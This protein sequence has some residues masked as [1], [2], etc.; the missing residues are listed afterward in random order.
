[1]RWVLY[2]DGAAPLSS[3]QREMRLPQTP[4][5]EAQPQRPPGLLLLGP[6]APWASS[7]P[8]PP[9]GPVA[10]SSCSQPGH[11]RPRRVRS[12]LGRYRPRRRGAGG[13]GARAAAGTM[14][15]IL[16]CPC[17]RRASAIA[18]AAPDWIY[19]PKKRPRRDQAAIAPRAGPARRPI[20]HALYR[21]QPASRRRRATT[22]PPGTSPVRAYNTAARLAEKRGGECGQAVNSA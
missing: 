12:G 7:P 22:H 15:S 16:S 20:P 4:G 2:A 14:P 1:V 5:A 3:R 8:L 11:S 21:Q 9:T 13:C 17:R 10:S 19:W 18:D 6:S